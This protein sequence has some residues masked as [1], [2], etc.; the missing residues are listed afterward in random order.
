[1]AST[2]KEGTER[3]DKPSNNEA[4]NIKKASA[5]KYTQGEDKA[6]IVVASGKGLIAEKIIDKAKEA[7]IPVYEDE[8]LAE[9]LSRISLGSEIP[10][11]LYGVVAEVLAFI[12]RLDE[13]FARRYLNE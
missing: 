4:Q 13:S 6:P 9:S 1:M 7:K 2:G 3:I 12:S 10:E 8:H 5:L 11:E